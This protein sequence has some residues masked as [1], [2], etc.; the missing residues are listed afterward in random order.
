VLQL[1]RSYRAFDYVFGVFFYIVLTVAVAQT[2][3]KGASPG[4]GEAGTFAVLFIFSQ[5]TISVLFRAINHSLE[6][7]YAATFNQ[8]Y[9]LAVAP[10]LGSVTVNAI[11]HV[12][13]A[14]QLFRVLLLAAAWR[15]TTERPVGVLR[16][17]KL[18]RSRSL[19]R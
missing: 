4:L 18:L 8:H 5:L 15:Y 2:A 9:A 3:A 11:E 6:H 14:G 12:S 10:V 7:D 1:P 17:V 19:R 13:F 16:T